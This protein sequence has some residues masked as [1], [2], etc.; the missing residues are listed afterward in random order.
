[1]GGMTPSERVLA[2]RHQNAPPPGQKI[3]YKAVPII[4][5]KKVPV[6][7]QVTVHRPN[8]RRAGMLTGLVCGG[9]IT[10]LS[11]GMEYW[12]IAA[13]FL[14]ALVLSF[15]IRCCWSRRAAAVGAASA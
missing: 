1:M 3:I 5:V 7:A 10:Y 2:N 4:I 6:L 9:A 14:G 11:M 8:D 13:A 12:E 15:G